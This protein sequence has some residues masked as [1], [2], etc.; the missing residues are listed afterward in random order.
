MVADDAEELVA[1]EPDV[2]VLELVTQGRQ[3]RKQQYESTS[4][5][6]PSCLGRFVRLWGK[7]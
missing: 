4:G 5:G 3:E 7:H 1:D 6:G 2:P